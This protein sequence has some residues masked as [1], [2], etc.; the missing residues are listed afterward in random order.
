[1]R[2]TRRR[3]G[4]LKI[5][6]GG[7]ALRWPAPSGSLG[8]RRA[9]GVLSNRAAADDAYGQLADTLIAKPPPTSFGKFGLRRFSS[10]S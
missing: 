4:R 9:T 5:S 3:S 10:A 6:E 2:P 8:Q 7:M 1:M